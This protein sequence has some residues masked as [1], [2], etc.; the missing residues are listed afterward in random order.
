MFFFCEGGKQKL[1]IAPITPWEDWQISWNVLYGTTDNTQTHTQ[2][3]QL[4]E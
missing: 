2:T 3:W 1:S 4:N